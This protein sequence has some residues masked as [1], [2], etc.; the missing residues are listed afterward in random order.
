MLIKTKMLKSYVLAYEHNNGGQKNI[1]VRRFI[2][3]M[4]QGGATL[5]ELN[6]KLKKIDKQIQRLNNTLYILYDTKYTASNAVERDIERIPG[7]SA[8][9]EN[10]E[11]NRNEYE[12]AHAQPYGPDQGFH[13]ISSPMDVAAIGSNEGRQ[14]LRLQRIRERGDRMLQKRNDMERERQQSKRHQQ[15]ID[16][17]NRINAQIEDVDKKIQTLNKLRI[18]IQNQINAAS[19]IEL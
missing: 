8:L 3:Y 18:D 5:D 13:L 11:N 17:V 6:A 4:I 10:I 19:P 7:Y 2:N 1:G 12:T 14:N 9:E 15:K 16:R